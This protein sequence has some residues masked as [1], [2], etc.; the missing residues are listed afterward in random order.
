ML[1]A[2]DAERWIDEPA[3]RT[4]PEPDHTTRKPGNTPVG[5]NSSVPEMRCCNQ[6]SRAVGVGFF[7]FLENR[8]AVSGTDHW[9]G[10][11]LP[12]LVPL[13]CIKRFI[14]RISFRI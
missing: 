12:L 2:S 6:R 8:I 11:G 5:R 10:E 9:C 7:S 3:A 1:S 14:S 13:I 4:E